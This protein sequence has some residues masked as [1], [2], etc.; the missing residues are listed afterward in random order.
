MFPCWT[1]LIEWSNEQKGWEEEKYWFTSFDDVIF[2]PNQEMF[3]C[4]VL[5]INWIWTHEFGILNCNLYFIQR[6]RNRWWKLKGWRVKRT[7]SSDKLT[8][9]LKM[10]KFPR[11][12]TRGSC[13]R[14]LSGGKATA[15]HDTHAFSP[16]SLLLGVNRKTWHPAMA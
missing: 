15:A 16:H 10:F 4:S 2:N 14:M 7:N 1:F 9:V 3:L 8:W 11:N 6:L 13:G 5:K 12:D